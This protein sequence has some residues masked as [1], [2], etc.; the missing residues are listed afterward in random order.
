MC[1]GNQ[2][3]M[4]VVGRCNNAIIYVCVCVCVCARVR[5]GGRGEEDLGT[6]L[7]VIS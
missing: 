5:V 2:K 4:L 7:S 6:I 3:V 1:D